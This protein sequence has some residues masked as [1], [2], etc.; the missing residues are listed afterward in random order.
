MRQ[1]VIGC[2]V[3]VPRLCPDETMPEF[4]KIFGKTKVYTLRGYRY[5]VLS[6][7]RKNGSGP[8]WLPPQRNV[9]LYQTPIKNPRFLR[10]LVACSIRSYGSVTRILRPLS[11][12]NIC[13]CNSARTLA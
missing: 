5:L 1:C 3:S 8:V 12:A 9:L 6:E 11:Q 2:K 13:S 7:F 10:V 4:S